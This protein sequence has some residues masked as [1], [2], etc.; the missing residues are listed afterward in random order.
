MNDLLKPCPVC[1]S[2]NVDYVFESSFGY[3][4]CQECGT[5][6]P[7]EDKAAD[8]ICDI[9]VAYEAWNTRNPRDDNCPFCSHGVSYASNLAGVPS[10]TCEGCSA[11]WPKHYRE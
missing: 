1:D 6:G 5:T 3:V 7:M 9:S 11:E 4:E 10:W 8:P 2:E